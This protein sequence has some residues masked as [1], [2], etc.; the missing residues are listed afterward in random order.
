MMALIGLFLFTAALGA[1]IGVV[2][3]TLWPALPRMA[4]LLAGTPD[5]V[6][7]EGVKFTPAPR[8]ADRRSLP[9]SVR[10]GREAWPIAA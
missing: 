10:R 5:M 9:T 4:A 6:V 2:V 8:R 3:R 7:P 1:V